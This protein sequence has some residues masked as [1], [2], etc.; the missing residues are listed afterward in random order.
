MVVS[1]FQTKHL[2]RLLDE[3]HQKM[4]FSSKLTHTYINNTFT[5]LL[6]EKASEFSRASIKI[7]TSLLFS[8]TNFLLCFSSS[9]TANF[10]QWCI[11]YKTDLSINIWCD[12]PR[13]RRSWTF[14]KFLDNTPRR[15]LHLYTQ[16]SSSMLETT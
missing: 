10:Q 8:N 11:T 15:H 6:S 9:P 14:F 5:N 3:R 2:S 1:Y 13:S 12:F 4:R 16:P 7:K